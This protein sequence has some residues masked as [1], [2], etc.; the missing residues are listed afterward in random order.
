MRGTT[1]VHDTVMHFIYSLTQ[2]IRLLTGDVNQ[3]SRICFH[4]TQTLS[5][6]SYCY[7]S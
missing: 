3:Y 1:L 7:A 4:Q 2:N 5:N 6:D